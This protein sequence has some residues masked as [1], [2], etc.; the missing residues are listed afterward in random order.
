MSDKSTIGADRAARFARRVTIRE[1]GLR[2][3][4][5][6][7]DKVLPTGH[8]LEWIRRAYAAGIR[9]M[10]VGGFVSGRRTPQL[11]DTAEL[12]AN[13]KQLPGMRVS[14]RAI[15]F[16]GAVQAIDHL[17][18]QL[19]VPCLADSTLSRS[20][21]TSPQTLAGI[22][23]IRAARDSGGAVTLLE[24]SIAEA[25]GCKVPDAH[26]HARII[27]LVSQLLDAGADRISLADTAGCA[28]PAAVSSLI[29]EVIHVAGDRLCSGHF[30][31]PH[32][33]ALT[34]I[35]AAMAAGLHHFDTSLAS[36]GG[37]VSDPTAE[38]SVAT[39]D[40]VRLL[41]TLGLSTGIDLDGLRNLRIDLASWLPGVPLFGHFGRGAAAVRSQ[42]E[43]DPI[44]H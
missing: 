9:Q 25:F 26:S 11:T 34:N 15:D 10:D 20:A 4:L 2:D 37:S 12:I 33:L 40:V 44:D 19:V 3:G 7:I 22:G 43:A 31:N 24:V 16:Y 36:L 17:A 30:Y 13:A 27:R 32:R 21:M 42:F 38:G 41:Q 29:A 8:K 14:V 1:V 5:Q 39:E 35:H 18:D 28:E 6:R 23:R